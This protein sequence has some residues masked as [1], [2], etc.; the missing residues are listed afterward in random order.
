MTTVSATISPNTPLD[1]LC[2]NTMRF[3]A[4]DAVQKAKSGHLGM[5]M[6]S[7][8]MAFA[9]WD[10][11]L[12]FNPREPAWPDRDRFV[13]SCGH[14]CMLQYA[15]LHLTG[16]DLPL[17]E[18]KR[19]RQWGSR[20]PGHPEFGITPGVEATT[21]PLGQGIANAVGMAMAETILAARFNRLDHVI[22][23]HYTYCLCSDG[24]LEEG[25]SSEAAGLAG[26]LK[27]GKLILLYADNRIQIEGGTDLAFTEDRERRFAAQEWHVQQVADG[28]EV[29][30]VTEAIR[31]ALSVEDRPSLIAVR[32]HIGYG[33]PHK[34][35]TNQAHSDPLGDEEVLLTKQNLGW[36]VE[37]TFLVPPDALAHFRKAVERG[38]RWQDE[39]NARFDAYAKAFPELAA[40]YQR[41]VKRELPVGWD[42]TL[43]SF[44]PSQ[45]PMA[46]RIASGKMIN[47]FSPRLTEFIGGSADLG[48]SNETMV[49]GG[50]DFQPA[51]RSGR[52]I[53]FGVRE[54]AMGGLMNGMALHGLIP[55]GGTFLVFSDYMRP[56]IR[57]AAM[58]GL[59]TIYVFTHD[60]IGLGEDGPTHQPV[61]HLLSLR[62]I[63]GLLVIRPADANETVAAWYLAMAHCEGP[64]AIVLSR[65]KLPILDQANH[66]EMADGVQMGG[67]VLADSDTEQPE[68]ILVA[69]G[70]EVHLALAAREQLA[71]QGATV[72]IVS[73]PCI[74]VFARQSVTYRN[75]VLPAGVPRLMIEAGVTLGWRSYF[76]STDTVVGVDRFGASAPGETVMREYGLTVDDVCQQAQR[77]LQNRG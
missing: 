64:V 31:S 44:A 18:I 57:L 34:Q 17:D 68:L 5:P 3:L 21:G 6:G 12:K 39:W 66:P 4:V 41:V 73:M 72:R 7:A 10:R 67:Y 27:L 62:A 47:L 58:N 42:A 24:D 46:T 23:D 25:L 15:L 61:E 37:P 45:G 8:A 1:E 16:F 65:Q 60:S 63:P 70:S 36:P 33:S 26:H 14:A 38:S 43:P 75:A 77:L 35:D 54:H 32:T 20:C 11:L 30:A 52:N 51:T 49:E 22:V 74:E 59:H 55:Y 9:L 56:A 2:I 71:N 29:E 69:T 19:F 28:N 40:E 13:L 50:G 76:D 53:H 48:P